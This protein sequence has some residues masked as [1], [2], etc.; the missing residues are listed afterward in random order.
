MGGGVKQCGVPYEPNPP[1]PVGYVAPDW[2]EEHPGDDAQAVYEPYLR[3]GAPQCE[4]VQ[5][6][7]GVDYAGGPAP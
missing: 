3:G 6:E 1:A 2:V 4:D 5:A 7:V